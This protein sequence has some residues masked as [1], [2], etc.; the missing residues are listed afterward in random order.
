MA[1]NDFLYKREVNK[2]VL[3]DGFGIER[4]YLNIFTRGIGK[5]NR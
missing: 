3:C 4:E 1:A 5:L 2:S